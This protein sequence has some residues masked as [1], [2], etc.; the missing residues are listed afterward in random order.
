MHK[1]QCLKHIVNLA[2]FVFIYS[3]FYN[4]KMLVED[5][6]IEWKCFEA[7]SKLHNIVVYIQRSLQRYEAFKEFLDDFKLQ[8]NNK[9]QWNLW[10]K[11]I[12]RI[13]KFKQALQVYCNEKHRFQIECFFLKTGIH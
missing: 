8:Q 9:I 13:L 1:M 12:E 6:N 10:F 2:V 3:D 7:F 4:N 5:A 11:N